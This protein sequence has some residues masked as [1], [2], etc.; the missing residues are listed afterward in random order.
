L[1][2]FR[3]KDVFLYGPPGTGKTSLASSCAYDAGANL[4]TVNRPEIISNYYGES[5]QSLYDVFGSAKITFFFSKMQ[6]SC[7]SLY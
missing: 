7:V 3:Q 4:F 5:E 2:N 1:I 6:E